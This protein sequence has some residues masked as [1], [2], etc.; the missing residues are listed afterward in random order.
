MAAKKY[1]ASGAAGHRSQAYSLSINALV[2]MN[3]L[4]GAVET[5]RAMLHELPYDGEAAYA[6]QFLKTYLVQAVDPRALPFATEEHAGLVEALKS[7]STLKSL[8]GGAVM[9]VGALYASGMQ[10]ALL[11]RYA[12]DAQG[13]ERTVGELEEAV[14]KSPSLTAPDVQWMGAVRK[15]YGLIGHVLPA[16]E[17]RG[18]TSGAAL[19]KF[20][21]DPGFVTI[22][23]VFPDYCPQCVKTVVGMKEFAGE[24]AAAKVHGYGLVVREDMGAAEPESW[25]ELKGTTLLA[26]DTGVAQTLGAVD[27]PL[28]VV[29]DEHGVVYFV[30]TVPANA[31]VPNGFMEQTIGR[32][33]GETAVM[34]NAV[35]GKA[36]QVGKKPN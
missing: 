16:M 23:M 22:V 26:V 9:G 19:R 1:L 25:K 15:Q 36:K 2:R 33:V 6:M 17:A 5:A 12:G 8:H 30:G 4:D 31:F 14:A 27:Y 28:F 34:R 13:A 11:Q 29:T 18:I 20:A 32:I 21:S 10:L 24:H 7:G 3:D 35:G